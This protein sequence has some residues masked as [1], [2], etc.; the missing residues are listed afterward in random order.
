MHDYSAEEMLHFLACCWAKVEWDRESVTV[1][2][3]SPEC[4]DV[5]TCGPSLRE[6]LTQMMTEA[7]ITPQVEGQRELGF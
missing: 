3:C 6:A 4:G 5:S 2:I 1:T 7:G